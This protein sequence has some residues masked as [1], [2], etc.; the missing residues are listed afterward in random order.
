VWSGRRSPVV[1]AAT[2]SDRGGTWG[3]DGNIYFAPTEESVILRVSAD[4]G[5]AEPVSALAENGSERSHRWPDLLPGGKALLIAVEEQ[6]DTVF[7]DADIQVLDLASGTRR[8]V[9]QGGSYPRYVPSGHLVYVREGTLL[10]AP[11]DLDQLEVTGPAVPVVESVQSF[12]GSGGVQ[13]SFSS[14]G[15]MVYLPQRPELQ[16]TVVRMD[17]AGKRRIVTDAPGS[18]DGPRF[19][20]DGRRVVVS[21]DEDLW[22]LDLERDVSTRLTFDAGF[23]Y[24]P[25]WSPDGRRIVYASRAGG[26]TNDNLFLLDAGGT[27]EPERIGSSE[28]SQYPTSWSPDGRWLLF[29]HDDYETNTDILMLSTDGEHEERIFLRTPFDEGRARVSPDGRWVTYSSNES[30][31]LEV[32]LRSFPGGEGKVQ[33]SAAGG[34]LPLWG[35]DGRRLFYRLG[36][37]V[38]EVELESGPPPRLGRPEV[39]VEGFPV[40]RRLGGTGNYDYDIA[41]DGRELVF[42]QPATDDTVNLQP[43]VVLNWFDDLRRLSPQ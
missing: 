16:S 30:G 7:D 38:L 14:T 11:F 24:N 31:R 12:S 15:T 8:T 19:S 34:D 5:S 20:P 33:V 39:V 17:L 29:D 42:L 37:T 36:D 25:V 10:A 21:L 6:T 27:G 9:I 23:N 26:L 43:R 18:F 35:P 2:K 4:G 13:L 3:R 40:F 32:Y 1:V 41:P 22:I 28:Y